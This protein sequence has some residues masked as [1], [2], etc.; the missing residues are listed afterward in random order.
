MGIWSKE[1]HQSWLWARVHPLLVSATISHTPSAAVAAS[2]RT[3]SKRRP[4]LLVDTLHPGCASTTGVR[5]LCAVVPQALASA[6]TSRRSLARPRMASAL[7]LPSAK[8]SNRCAA[9][10]YGAGDRIQPLL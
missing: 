3:T 8:Q 6:H 10:C 9:C 2:V 4:V 7:G 1:R 5:R